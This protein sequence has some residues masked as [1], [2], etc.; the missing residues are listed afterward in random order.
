[1]EKP[2]KALWSLIYALKFVELCLLPCHS[3]KEHPTP[4]TTVDEFR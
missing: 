4:L 1:M 3:C 2:D